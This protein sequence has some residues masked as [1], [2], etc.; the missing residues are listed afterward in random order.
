MYFI[1]ETEDQL[2]KLTKKQTCFVRL[3]TNND[4]YHPAIS[5]PCLVY[6]NDGDK[7]YVICAQHSESFSIDFEKIKKFIESHEKVYVIDKKFHSYFIDHKAL[8]DIN[9]SVLDDNNDVHKYDC[10]CATKKDFYNKFGEDERVNEIVPISKHYESAECLY[11]LV[12]DKFGYEKGSAFYDD[13][14][15]AYKYVESQGLGVAKYYED[16]FSVKN[17][18]F[19]EKDNV[20]YSSYNLYNFTGRPTNAFNG[21]NFLAIPKTKEARSL[22]VPKR[23]F[24]VEFDF[25]GYH[26]RLIANLLGIKLSKESV[27]VQ[28]GKQYFS[29]NELTKEEY[30]QSK[31]LTFRQLYG[32]VEEEYKHVEFFSKMEEYIDAQYNVYMAQG[33]YELPTGRIIRHNK[34][35]TRLK[36]FNYA[37]Q[38]YE[39]YN[40]VFAINAIR[41]YLNDKHS[42]LVLVTYDAFLIDF[43]IRDSKST[44]IGIKNILEKG[45]ML[46]KHKH[47][48]SYHFE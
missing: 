3:I 35:I 27:H 22:I 11:E 37:I 16:Y 30:N 38:N 17:S 40:N 20:V 28:L 31:I 44:L 12:K 46:V 13:L 29:K 43:D 23:D 18:K 32:G 6:Y 7:G 36:L 2:S 47:S 26:V 42:Q 5:R 14:C 1:V 41:E 45:G 19:F 4:N 34:S 10:D 15:E 48:K 9:F 39:T 24:F 21:V 25:D 8:V 33:Y